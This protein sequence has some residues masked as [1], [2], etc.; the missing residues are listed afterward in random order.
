MTSNTDI[1][2]TVKTP[3]SALK[4]VEDLHETA[5]NTSHQ[6]MSPITEMDPAMVETKESENTKGQEEIEEINMIHADRNMQHREEEPIKKLGTTSSQMCDINKGR[7]DAKR[8]R[9]AFNAHENTHTYMGISTHG[10]SAID[11]NIKFELQDHRASLGAVPQITAQVQTGPHTKEVE[12]DAELTDCA[13]DVDLEAVQFSQLTTRQQVKQCPKGAPGVSDKKRNRSQEGPAKTDQNTSDEKHRRIKIHENKMNDGRDGENELDPNEDT[14]KVMTVR[15]VRII[16]KPD[17]EGAD[18]GFYKDPNDDHTEQ[19]GNSMNVPLRVDTAFEEPESGR[20]YEE[21]TD[22]VDSAEC[23]EGASAHAHRYRLTNQDIETTLLIAQ[24][25]YDEDTDNMPQMKLF[26]SSTVPPKDHDDVACSKPNTSSMEAT[27]TP[28]TRNAD[29]VYANMPRVDTSTVLDMVLQQAARDKKQI[30]Q[31]IFQLKNRVKWLEKRKLEQQV[32]PSMSSSTP[33]YS[34]KH[35]GVSHQQRRPEPDNIMSPSLHPVLHQH[36]QMYQTLTF[37]NDYHDP[38]APVI[39]QNVPEKEKWGQ[40]DKDYDDFHDD[41]ND[42]Q[43]QMWIHMK[44]L[45]MTDLGTESELS[46]EEEVEMADI[47]STDGHEYRVQRDDNQTH[48]KILFDEDPPDNKENWPISKA[49]KRAEQRRLVKEELIEFVNNQNDCSQHK[50]TSATRTTF[51]S[52]TA[53]KEVASTAPLK[54]ATKVITTVRPDDENG[55]IAILALPPVISEEEAMMNDDYK[56]VKPM[57]MDE[58]IATA[59]MH[60]LHT[61]VNKKAIIAQKE[62]V[63]KVTFKSQEIH[64]IACKRDDNKKQPGNNTSGV[65]DLHTREDEENHVMVKELPANNNMLAKYVNEQTVPPLKE[66]PTDDTM[67]TKHKDSH[68]RNMMKH[69]MV[70]LSTTNDTPQIHTISSQKGDEDR[71]TADLRKEEDYFGKEY[72]HNIDEPYQEDVANYY[73]QADGVATKKEL[74]TCHGRL[75]L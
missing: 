27:R 17:I 62:L 35:Q 70:T 40:L 38:H 71:P 46:Y 45:T 5:A 33:N 56:V 42:A 6:A 47:R 64:E 24:D 31:E 57:N 20:R 12:E 32:G 26:S 22:E 37:K 10:D 29:H 50:L 72:P 58:K 44:E 48:L 15:E 53:S 41:E 63:A 23:Q 18:E 75:R 66:L 25:D 43:S 36:G 69:Q 60:G 4:T 13:C 7:Y 67:M 2:C 28:R 9:P 11:D 8:H 68:S 74:K 65:E 52:A 14:H 3:S 21:P 19:H 30:Q 39:T 16:Y 1:R 59:D 55:P 51:A 73:E 61:N 49:S 34:Q 54:P